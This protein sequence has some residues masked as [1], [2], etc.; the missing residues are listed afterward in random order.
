MGTKRC[1]KCG[2]LKDESEFPWH[3]VGLKRHSACS[4]CRKIYQTDYYQRKKDDFIEKRKNWIVDAREAARHYVYSYLQTHPCEMCGESDPAVLTFH[5]VRGKKKMN[6]SQ[7]VNQG[8][9]IEALQEEIDKCQVLCAN[10][11]MR[12]EKGKRG[13]IYWLL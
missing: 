3:F 5:H 1:S 12:V 9:S 10:D 7:M 6:L 4:E 13:T 11:H 8:Y 2:L